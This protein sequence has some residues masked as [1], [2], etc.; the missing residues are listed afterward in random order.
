VNKKDKRPD[1]S[2]KNDW[3]EERRSKGSATTPREVA[4]RDVNVPGTAGAGQDPREELKWARR[5]VPEDYAVGSSGD[6]FRKTALHSEPP[7]EEE[8]EQGDS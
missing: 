1:M 5:H 4:K 2:D 8:E 7:R 6:V 3:N